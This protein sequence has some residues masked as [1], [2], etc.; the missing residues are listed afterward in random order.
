M[1]VIGTYKFL[2]KV[3]QVNAEKNL[4]NHKSNLENYTS[5]ERK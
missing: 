2:K 1:F 3:V 4:K 5:K